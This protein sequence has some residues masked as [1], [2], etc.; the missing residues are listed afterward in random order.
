M[1][2]AAVLQLVEDLA[3]GIQLEA[4]ERFYDQVVRTSGL[5]ELLVV[6]LTI[7]NLTAGTAVYSLPEMAIRPIA[8]LS[9]KGQLDQ[10]SRSQIEASKGSSWRDHRGS[11]PEAVVREDESFRSYRVYPIPSQ[12]SSAWI[13][14]TGEPL[15]LDLPRDVLLVFHTERREDLPA[16]YDLLFALRIVALELATES[17]HADP[18]AAAVAE[19]LAKVVERLVG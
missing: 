4:R 3:P 14:V 19:Q 17:E 5:V 7:Q 6:N 8:F 16:E 12:T 15:G 1:G 11:T 10:V 18:K 13:P 9:E 2:R